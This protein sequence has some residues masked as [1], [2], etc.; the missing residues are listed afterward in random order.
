MEPAGVCESLIGGYCCW[1]GYKLRTRLRETRDLRGSRCTDCCAHCMC[2]CVAL[3]R[4]WQEAQAD[5]FNSWN[6]QHARYGCGQQ[7]QANTALVS[8][9]APIGLSRERMPADQA[10]SRE[11]VR[12]PGGEGGS[13]EAGS[14]GRMLPSDMFHG[15]WGP[16]PA[17]EGDPGVQSGPVVEGIELEVG[18]HPA[19]VIERYQRILLEQ[20]GEKEMLEALK[21]MTIGIPVGGKKAADERAQE[22][23]KIRRELEKYRPM[24]SSNYTVTGVCSI[25]KALDQD[26]QRIAHELAQAEMEGSLGS[27]YS[28]EKCNALGKRTVTDLRSSLADEVDYIL[29]TRDSSPHPAHIMPVKT[30][31]SKARKDKVRER[32]VD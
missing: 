10:M 31:C 7:P 15:E 24:V 9:D 19:D 5:P 1:I 8:S 11:T 28:I 16:I 3:A 22:V 4:V 32:V 23:Q 21:H 29:S 2:H 12:A 14:S 13:G 26:V 20:S 6:I 25:E 27:K 18:L 30:L 17:P